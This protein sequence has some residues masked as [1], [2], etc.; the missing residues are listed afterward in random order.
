MTSS[1]IRFLWNFNTNRPKV[2]LSYIPNFILIEHKKAELIQ[3]REVHI[4]EKMCVTSLWPWQWP[5]M[6]Y[7]ICSKV[8]FCKYVIST[9]CMVPRTICTRRLW[10]SCHLVS[11]CWIYTDLPFLRVFKSNVRFILVCGVP[12]GTTPSPPNLAY[13]CNLIL[14][15]VGQ[16]N[17]T[18]TV[19][20]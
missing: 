11:L 13:R 3:S 17:Y 9:G 5:I 2:C 18:V 1:P 20:T 15:P 7:S 4:E 10:W 12:P 16:V 19:S 8:V 6:F 14:L